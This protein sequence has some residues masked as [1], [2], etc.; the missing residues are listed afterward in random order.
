MVGVH[1]PT[2]RETAAAAALLGVKG[3]DIDEAM[4]LAEQGNWARH[5]PG[6][7]APRAAP[8]V[9]VG[10]RVEEL[11]AHWMQDFERGTL[12]GP[13]LAGAAGAS[14]TPGDG[15]Q[16]PENEM[17]DAEAAEQAGNLDSAAADV[18]EELLDSP[19]FPALRP[20]DAAAA[21]PGKDAE[22]T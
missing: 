15:E 3:V 16:E 7:W 14:P 1:T 5:A 22:N 12:E 21:A 8:P 20:A 17:E 2:L 13:G 19:A 4:E 18:E 11:E 9:P 6:P 10:R